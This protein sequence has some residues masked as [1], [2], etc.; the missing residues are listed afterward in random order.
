[1]NYAV[2]N[3]KVKQHNILSE[4]VKAKINSL[5]KEKQD[6]TL[7][8]A[9]SLASS[10]HYKQALRQKDVSKIELNKISQ[11]YKN[12]IEFKNIWLQIVDKEG[13]SF[14]RSW[15]RKVGENL[16]LMRQDIRNLLSNKQPISTISVGVFSISFKSM[17]PIFDGDEF[18]GI[19]EIVAH[20]NSI[21]KKLEQDDYESVV[22]ADKRFK[23]QLTRNISK[24][25]IGD[26]YV[27]NFTPN[28][29]LVNA[30]REI[31]YEKIFKSPKPYNKYGDEHLFI[32]E[33]IKNVDNELIGYMVVLTDDDINDSDITSIRLVFTLYGLLALLALSAFAF[34]LLDKQK[35]VS[36]LNNEQYGKR[37]LLYFVL[38][39]VLFMI[40]VHYFL[41]YE[42]QT[43][44]E[45]FLEKNN[46]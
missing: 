3:Y 31:D 38:F 26:Y 2:D 32:V 20:F 22:L 7:A 5:I 39:Y 15:T 30:L 40:F 29:R 25:F 41:Q 14:A 12:K 35:I 6:T 18:L 4:R 8:M 1:M 27:G 16:G 33:Q 42:K 43:K 45:Q 13:I 44:I 21:E 28:M 23:N 11:D 17:V 46:K 36:H 34:F 24:T 19:F 9:L 10:D 37:L